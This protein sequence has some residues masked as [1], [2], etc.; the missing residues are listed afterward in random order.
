MIIGLMTMSSRSL[1]SGLR[2][3]NSIMNEW[4]SENFKWSEFGCRCGECPFRNGYQI[5]R[6]LVISLQ[7]IR[8]YIGK[9]MMVSS[10]LRCYAHNKAEGGVEKSFHLLGQAADIRCTD[11]KLRRKMILMG[12]DMGLTIGINPKYLH[13]DNRRG[14]PEMFLC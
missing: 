4:V 1:P 2:I 3:Y 12:L 11:S 10:G 5:N 9:P 14:D 8:D 7:R 13:F 6:H